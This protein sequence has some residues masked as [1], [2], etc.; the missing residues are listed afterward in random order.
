MSKQLVIPIEIKSRELQAACLLASEF[1]KNGWIV[2]IGQKQQLF[3]YIRSFSKAVWFL[4]SI[5]PGEISLLKKIKKSG[6]YIA[7]LDVEGL[8]TH[9]FEKY[10]YVR[11]NKETIKLTNL[12]FFWNKFHY[13]LVKK[14][15]NKRDLKKFYITGS[16]IM[17]LWKFK[18]KKKKA[19]HILICTSFTIANNY[20][21]KKILNL[22][23]DNA[24]KKYS[25]LF[26][27]H[28]NKTSIY[29]EIG[30][31]SYVKNL[32][33]IFNKYKHKNFVI[34]PHPAENIKIWKNF[35]NKFNN[36]IVDCKTELTDLINNSS[37]VI[38][39]N[40]TAGVQAIVQ[41]KKTLN[42]FPYKKK[43]NLAAPIFKKTDQIIYKEKDFLNLKS[44]KIKN[45]K[46]FFLRNNKHFYSTKKIFEIINSTFS[47]TTKEIDPFKHNFK[48]K[49]YFFDYKLR[50]FI[51]FI[52][53][54]IKILIRIKKESSTLI[55]AKN[56]KYSSHKWSKTNKNEINKIINS[57]EKSNLIIDQ[58]N[59]GFF[60]IKKDNL[61]K[62]L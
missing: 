29:Y 50:N 46:N 25:S 15:S 5:V 53:L 30:F 10:A 22:F 38:H 8:V 26:K 45:S 57:F 20:F 4:K 28:L 2:Y 55:F 42:Y 41:G 31:K 56:K 24:D 33:K 51:Y 35:V 48:S 11:Y 12:I 7:T 47:N 52:I 60:R 58:F 54:K 17:D 9:S 1:C 62:Q 32:G 61:K 14:I 44:K 21:G 34:K 23:T 36:V 3:P 43:Y 16:P 37:Q 13:N 6:N 59:D 19:K 49:F 18:K 40:S 39:F 27:N